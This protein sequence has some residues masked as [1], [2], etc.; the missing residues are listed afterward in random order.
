M[1]RCTR[2]YKAIVISNH[3][4]PALSSDAGGGYAPPLSPQLQRV[5]IL[6]EPLTWHPSG[7]F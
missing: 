7:S 1:Y 2:E 4:G 6:P 3:S 5:A